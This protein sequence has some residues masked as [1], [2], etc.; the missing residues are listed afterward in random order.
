M[1]RLSYVHRGDGERSLIGQP[2]HASISEV[3]HRFPNHDAV[4][5]CWQQR[6]LTYTDLMVAS[7]R[8]AK[9]LLA[10]GVA[11]GD[12][13]GVWA[14]DC[15]EWV[16]LQLAT[17][18]IGAVLV[19][20]NPAY[21]RGEIE[22]ALAAARVQVLFLIP[23]FKRSRYA[24]IVR[25][26]CPELETRLP[27]ARPSGQ[28]IRSARF[29]ELRH[30]VIFDPRE[31]EKTERPAR[32][33]LTWSDVLDR[34]AAVPSSVETER[35]AH[36]DCDDPINIQFT[37]GTTGFPKPVVLTHHNILN[38]G[39]FVGEALRMDENDRLCVPVPFY[40][41]FGMV[42]SNLG[43]FTHG[44]CLV[45]PEAHFGAGAVLAAVERERCTLLHGVP[46]MFVAELE[47]EEFPN[48]DLSSLRGGI[49]AGA[50]CPPELMR[51]V[52][53]EMGMRDLR[54][55]YGQTEASPVTHCT[56][57]N[58]SVARRTRTV[59]YN[60]PHQEVKV[61]DPAS[62]EM[63]PRGK[64]GEI[65]FR[66]YHVMR[67]YFEMPEATREAIDERGWLHSGDL[68]V[69][70]DEGYLAIT[71]RLKDMVI[72]GGENIYPAE[73]EAYLCRHP[74]V[75]QA[76]VF[77]L[78]HERWGED[79]GAWVQLHGGER[80]T[81]EEIR[82]FVA[83][84]LAHFKVPSHVRIVDE[85]PMTVTGKIQKFRIREVVEAELGAEQAAH[86]AAERT[87]EPC[88]A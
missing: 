54:V 17:A 72:R 11:K 16:E 50:P 86:S 39:W 70:D 85:F 8:L 59:G 82:E 47:H 3:A 28:R 27:D 33:F 37:S 83:E 62:G 87:L 68:G 52:I 88:G 81:S 67:G 2:I 42:I 45:I 46:T 66:G 60:L 40:H 36:L 44:S 65:C 35:E 64:Q 15:V 20:L 71:G 74:K 24:D 57:A 51:R 55:A 4:V 75:A 9:G 23:S 10:L 32:G 61:V 26:L 48:F 22:H 30:V 79:L 58:D 69:L 34:G 25:Q 56:R 29:P 7:S 31:V 21:R 19:S 13:V 6:R 41:C 12:R 63:L 38:N 43:C 80:A 76:A 49:M 18:E 78:A 1:S 53:D 73:I 5:S 14:T 77:G 84:G